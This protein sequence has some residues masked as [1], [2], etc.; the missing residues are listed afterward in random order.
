MHIVRANGVRADYRVVSRR[1]GTGRA[2]GAPS[3]LG[4]DSL[5]ALDVYLKVGA[6]H[7]LALVVDGVHLERHRVRA[8][9]REI[10]R[11]PE[12]ESVNRRIE[13]R[14]WRDEWR[15]SVGVLR[16]GGGEIVL[17]GEKKRGRERNGRMEWLKSIDGD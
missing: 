14:G 10:L 8:H 11:L 12:E 2:R 16:M 3:E 1:G 13:G 4:A 17:N 15:G 7:G 6:L 9:L 5:G